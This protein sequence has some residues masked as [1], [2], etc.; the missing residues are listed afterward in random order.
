MTK[1]AT[2]FLSL[3]IVMTGFMMY[4]CGIKV[5]ADKAEYA[6]EWQSPQMYLL[7]L[8]DG[9]V[10]YSRISGGVTKTVSGPLKSFEGNNF[11]VGVWMVKTTF[12]VSEPPHLDGNQW[13]MTVDGVTLVKTASY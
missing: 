11:V 7:I 5:P 9:S 6:G 3:L 4:G 12:V 2:I 1:R 10:K 8:P 13:K